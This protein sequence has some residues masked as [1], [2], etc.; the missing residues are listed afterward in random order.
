[1][2]TQQNYCP[3]CGKAMGEEEAKNPIDAVI[4]MLEEMRGEKEEPAEEDC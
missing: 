4:E 1:M 3:H 2:K